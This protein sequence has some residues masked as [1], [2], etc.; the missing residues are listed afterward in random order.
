MGTSSQ[1]QLSYQISP[2]ILTNGIAERIPGGM[3]P[4]IS[5]LESRNFNEGLLSGGGNIKPDDFFAQFVPMP[6]STLSDQDVATYTFAN[7]AVA[8]NAVIANPLK[9]SLRMICPAREKGGYALKHSTML[10]LKDQLD[11]HNISGGTYTVATPSYIWA[12]CLLLGVRDLG[13]DTK[14]AQIEWQ[15]DFLQPLLTEKQAAISLNNLMNLLTKATRINGT[16]AWSGLEPTVGFTPSLAGSSVVP[17]AQ[18]SPA[19]NTSS[20]AGGGLRGSLP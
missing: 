9:I 6:G 4:I 10:N 1:F 11:Q 2:I 13:S 5:I 20:A 3:L 18:P 14:Q 12:D 16:P 17:A 15:W 8:A 19:S 7:R